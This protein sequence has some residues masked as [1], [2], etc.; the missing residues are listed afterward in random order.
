MRFR[1]RVRV[2]PRPSILD[3]QGQAVAHALGELGFSGV[4][5]V[6][7][8]RAMELE[9]DAPSA[10][11]ARAGA[12]KMCERLLANPVTEDFALDTVEQER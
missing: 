9:L 10:D 8:G 11:A 12:L 3:P 1:A 5:G 4:A 6:R 2:M 7:V